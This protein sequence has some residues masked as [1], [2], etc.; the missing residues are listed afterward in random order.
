MKSKKLS[1]V[2]GMALTLL[3]FQTQ[4]TI[5]TTSEEAGILVTQVS[6]ATTIDFEGSA[7]CPYASCSGDYLIKTNNGTVWDSNGG[8][9]APYV[10]TGD[11]ENFLAVPNPRSNGSATFQLDGSYDY[12]G[13]F[14]GSIDS[15]NS[16]SFHDGSSLVGSFSG[17]DFVPPLQ[18]DGS[19]GQWTSN[20]FVNFFFTDGM[21]YDSVTLNSQGYAFESDNHAY[22]N[23]T[24]VP[25]PSV[26]ALMAA[27][28]LGLGFSRRLKK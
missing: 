22:G 16:I 8:A 12:F 13:F 25:E 5:I 21:T 24:S 1:I 27:G 14:W 26:A 17:D 28:L 15:Y 6:E 3:T 10:A 2:A 19:Q 7:S 11:G 23:M 20:R 9:A 18:A 4:A